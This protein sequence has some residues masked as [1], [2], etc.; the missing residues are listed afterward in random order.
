[1]EI[2]WGAKVSDQFKGLVLQMCDEFRINPNYLMA[3]IAFE[4]AETFKSDIRNAA[5]SGAVGLIQFMPQTAAIMHTTIE[6]LAA[7]TPEQQLFY[8]RLY[9]LPFRSRLITLSDVYSA[10]LW[11]SAI[12]KPENA[13]IFDGHDD[14]HPKLYLQNKGLDLNHDGLI[15][16]FEIAASVQRKL[17]KGL[18]PEFVG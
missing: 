11:P 17:E 14:N 2:A 6:A 9:F 16:K 4:S 5:G 1:M 13:I 7:K 18:Q 10:I 12:G 15:Q 8:V 3:C